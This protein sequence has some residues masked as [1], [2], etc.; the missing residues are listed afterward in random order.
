MIVRRARALE[1]GAT[2]VV[3]V[4]VTVTVV[5]FVV[6]PTAQPARRKRLARIAARRL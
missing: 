4:R 6:P 5:V 1:R 3:T 2:G